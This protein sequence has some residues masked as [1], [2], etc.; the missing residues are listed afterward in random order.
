[1]FSFLGAIAVIQDHIVNNKLD[2]FNR[3]A[4]R[5]NSK[6]ST[7]ENRDDLAEMKEWELLQVLR[8]ISVIGRST[9][10]ELENCLQRRNGCGHPN[11]YRVGENVAA[12]HLETLIDNVYA[13]F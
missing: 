12:A 13:R 9:K 4:R 6:W 5:R 3:E 1:M 10:H 7:A 2:E 8:G 11:D